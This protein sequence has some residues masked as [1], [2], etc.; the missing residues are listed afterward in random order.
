MILILKGLHILPK[1]LKL[2]TTVKCQYIV[3]TVTTW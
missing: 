2:E 1:K 3:K